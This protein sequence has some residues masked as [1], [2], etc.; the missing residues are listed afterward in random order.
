[1]ESGRRVACQISPKSGVAEPYRRAVVTAS[2][3]RG[4]CEVTVGLAAVIF[5]VAVSVL[6]NAFPGVKASHAIGLAY[7]IAGLGNAAG[8]L[9]GGLL[10]DVPWV[11]IGWLNVPLSVRWHS[12][13]G[14]G[15]IGARRVASTSWAGVAHSRNRLVHVDL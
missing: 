9:I 4:T 12:A 10:T 1:M 2:E 13:L 11:W 5:P 8:P 3:S 7:G 6:T 15:S 14:S